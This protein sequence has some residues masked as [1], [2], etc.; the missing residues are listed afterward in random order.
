MNK[1]YFNGSIALY[2]FLIRSGSIS[3]PLLSAMANSAGGCESNT[4]DAGIF[5]PVLDKLMP[6]ARNAWAFGVALLIVIASLGGLYFALKGA[7][8][9]S[10]G[11]SRDDQWRH[12]WNGSAHP[13]GIDG[14]PA[15]ATVELHAAKLCSCRALLDNYY[16]R[17]PRSIYPWR[18]RLA[19]N[20]MP[21][22]R[23]AVLAKGYAGA[24]DHDYFT[25]DCP[26]AVRT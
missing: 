23:L 10:V 8:G 3:H 7:A 13:G 6:L 15:P 21:A 18:G 25:G 11:G 1:L 20:F 2:G 22:A 17:R 16:V 19:G 9:A 4:G 24:G 5:A 14:I 12:Y 26:G